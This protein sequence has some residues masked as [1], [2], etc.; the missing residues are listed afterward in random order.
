MTTSG[1]TRSGSLFVRQATGLVREISPFDA[2]IGNLVI[3]GLVVA[4][5]TML[6]LPSTFTGVNVPLSVIITFFLVLFPA[7]VY[8]LFGMAMPRS[9]GDYVFISRSIP[10]LAGPLLGFAAN[11]TI[12]AWNISWQGL[13]CNWVST[14]G[15]SGSFYVLGTI[16]GS[17][18]LENAGSWFGQPWPAILVGSIV[19]IIVMGVM[20]SGTRYALRMQ[21]TLILISI[22]GLIVAIITLAFTAHSTF[23]S[24]FNHVANYN[25]I[26]K[27]GHAAGYIQPSGWTWGDTFAATGL[28]MLSMVFLMYAV[29]AGGE[30][31]NASRTIPFSILGCL[32]VGTIFIFVMAVAALHTFGTNFLGS[33]FDLYYVNPGKYP[34]SV[35][36]TYQLFS[37][38]ASNSVPIVVLIALPFILWN[39]AA[40]SMNTLANTR[41]IFAWAFD[42]LLP[43]QL[44]NVNER[45]HTPVVAIVLNGVLVEALLVFYTFSNQSAFLSGSDLGYFL[46]FS[47]TALAALIFPFRLKD[48]YRSSPA[49]INIAGIPLIT[50]A[51]IG[52]IAYFAYLMY[53]FFTKA[54]YGANSTTAKTYLVIYFVLGIIIFLGSWI[55]RRM[56]NVNIAETYQELPAE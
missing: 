5:L 20:I 40:V 54:A 31:K 53:A 50:L 48:V 34:L 24:H 11:F 47:V 22:L 10:S 19:N 51:G 39:V 52:T 45:T 7:G 37:S 12:V 29:Y 38:I 30:V 44:A 49:N 18:A 32:I 1:I 42:R 56:Q 43:S 8:I 14:Q 15:L 41:C 33:V 6:L 2:L 27:Q 13:Y 36:P 55:Y 16:T 21:N 25:S 9:G 26:I 17:K 35:S 4:S 3:F 23:V 28:N 46:A